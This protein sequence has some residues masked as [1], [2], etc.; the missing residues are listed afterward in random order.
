MTPEQ[1]ARETIDALLRQAGWYLCNVASRPT[2]WCLTPNACKPTSKP[3]WPSTSR[4]MQ[5]RSLKNNNTG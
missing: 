1:K 4:P 5:T 2:N 3:G